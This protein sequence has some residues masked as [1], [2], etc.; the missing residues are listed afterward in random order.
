MNT[1][2]YDPMNDTKNLTMSAEDTKILKGT[3][4]GVINTV[5]IVSHQAGNGSAGRVFND[6][7][8]CCRVHRDEGPY[9]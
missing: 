7:V 9:L 3:R 8:D 1:E 4:R 5:V 2:Q 6:A